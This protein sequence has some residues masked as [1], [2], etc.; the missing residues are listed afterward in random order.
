M[1]KQKTDWELL[2][3]KLK[4]QFGEEPQTDALLFLIGV[5]E[6]NKGFVNLKKDDKMN[7]MHIAICRLLEPYGFYTFE[8]RDNEGWPHYKLNEKIP[9]LSA[10][11]QNNLMTRAIIEYFKTNEFI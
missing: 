3:E 7:V 9:A 2:M 1:Q 6:L 8:G 4:N 5:N 11:E 10:S